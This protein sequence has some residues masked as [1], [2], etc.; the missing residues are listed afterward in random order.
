[1]CIIIQQPR[2]GT[3]GNIYIYLY[4]FNSNRGGLEFFF[5]EFRMEVF[6]GRRRRLIAE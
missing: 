4:I 6:S 3:S 5:F 2:D 1:M